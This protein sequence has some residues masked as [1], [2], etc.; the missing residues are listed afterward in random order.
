MCYFIADSVKY[1]IINFEVSRM[2]TLFFVYINFFRNKKKI[3]DICL[4]SALLH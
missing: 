2:K 4:D 1:N 3:Q